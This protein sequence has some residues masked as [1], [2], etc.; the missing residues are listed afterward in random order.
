[1]TGLV[2]AWTLGVNSNSPP[3]AF[4]IGANASFR[5]RAA[6]LTG[7]LAVLDALTQGGAISETVGAGLIEGV[8]ITGLARG[9]RER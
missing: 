8:V 6:F 5:M 1:M 2:P 3:F 7:T 4:A 9:V